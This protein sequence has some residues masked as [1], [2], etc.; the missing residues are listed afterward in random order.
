MVNYIIL[1]CLL[2]FS[3]ISDIKYSKILNICVI[4]AAISGLFINAFEYGAQG[5]KASLFGALVPILLLGI[6]FCLELIGAGDIKLFSAIGS[7]L[8]FEFILY[9]MAYSFIFAGILSSLILVRNKKVQAGNTALIRVIVSTFY[10]F[11]LNIKMCCLTSSICYPSIGKKHFIRF[12][13]YIA[14][15]TCLQVILSFF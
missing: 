15:G 5:L 13:P 6:L 9:G 12:S 14:M 10:H 1:I 3:I 2:I 4:P 7:L 8:G 11:Y